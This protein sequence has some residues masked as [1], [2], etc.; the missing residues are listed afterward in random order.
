MEYEYVAVDHKGNRVTGKKWSMSKRQLKT[1]L[2]ANKLC[3]VNCRANWMSVVQTRKRLDAG[4]ILEFSRQMAV[5]IK[6]GLSLT[7]AIEI[8]MT[9]QKDNRVVRSLVQIK[10]GIEQGNALVWSLQQASKSFEQNYCDV[11]AVGEQTGQLAEAF[12]QNYVDLKSRR[13]LQ[14][15]LRQA[16][17][18]PAIVFLVAMVLVSILLVKVI[19]SFA[20]LFASFDQSLPTSTQW[21]L[22]LSAVVQRNSSDIALFALFSIG[23]VGI[24]SRSNG[25]RRWWCKTSLNLPV[26]GGLKKLHFYT[27]FTLQCH[28]LLTSGMP[29]HQ[30]IDKLRKQSENSV[31]Q[32][33]MMQIHQTLLTGGSFYHA[34]KESKI[35]PSLCLQLI[36]V[37][38]STGSLDSRLKD[39]TEIYQ[40][41]FDQ[42][43]TA[44][45]ALLEPGIMILMGVIIGG[46]VLVLYLPIFSM[47][48]TM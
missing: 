17:M 5:L 15:R 21:V 1:E 47:A 23:G 32:A 41:K 12:E 6:A 24:L 35:F 3:L 42:K 29:L 43:I 45:L 20:D 44:A 7:Q 13:H 2:I 33:Q 48:G 38:E 46:L 37:G 11:I 22:N 10:A 4:F 26:W 25:C 28:N 34:C 40:Q 27:R 31:W 8:L 14:K 39:A 30:V 36:K 18:Y 19:P 9:E 16:C